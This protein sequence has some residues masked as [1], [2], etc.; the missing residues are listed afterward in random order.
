MITVRRV[1]VDSEGLGESVDRA[2][3][4]G[5]H[6]QI[7]FLRNDGWSLGAPKKYELVAF[8]LWKGDWVSFS[9]DMETWLPIEQYIQ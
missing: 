1:I 7:A 9:R 5:I 6:P 8:T 4:R 2:A 3:E